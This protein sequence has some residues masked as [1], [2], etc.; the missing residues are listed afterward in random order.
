[1]SKPIWLI[2]LIFILFNSSISAVADSSFDRGASNE[3]LIRSLF[4]AFNR[5]DVEGLATLYAPD[6]YLMSSDFSAPRRGPEGVRKT[7]SELFAQLPQIRDEVKTLIVKGDEAAVEFVSTWNT[8][9]NTPAGKLE[10][11]TFFKFK[12]GRIVSDVT[13]F[14]SAS[15]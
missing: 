5:H 9:E 10:I 2:S 14:N 8:G 1:M 12:N 11:A 6:A 3:R 4:D 13:Y 7:Y 15:K